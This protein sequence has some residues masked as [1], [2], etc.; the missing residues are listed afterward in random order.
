MNQLLFQVINYMKRVNVAYDCK[1]SEVN[2][3]T[4]IEELT[5]TT[6]TVQMSKRGFVPMEQLAYGFEV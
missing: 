1:K 2:T 6:Y 4:L 5:N 3:Y